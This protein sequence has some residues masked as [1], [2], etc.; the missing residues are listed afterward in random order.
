MYDSVFSRVEIKEAFPWKE[1][2]MEK[3]IVYEN[4]DIVMYEAREIVEV[5]NNKYQVS[6]NPNDII[7]EIVMVKKMPGYN[8]DR[9]DVH[10]MFKKPKFKKPKIGDLYLPVFADTNII[11]ITRKLNE[12]IDYINQDGAVNE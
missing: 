9:A 3:H 7:G 12:V 1:V 8:N 5:H 6:V 2:Y 4:D 10:Y 11:A